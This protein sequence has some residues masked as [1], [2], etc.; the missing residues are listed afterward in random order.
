MTQLITL[1]SML[2]NWPTLPTKNGINWVEHWPLPVEEHL[3]SSWKLETA[4]QP[5]PF[6]DRF[7]SWLITWWARVLGVYKYGILWLFSNQV[8]AALRSMLWSWR[9][10]FRAK[11][12]EDERFTSRCE[13]SRS[14][15]RSWRSILWTSC[16]FWLCQNSY[17]K[18]QVI[19]DL[20][21]KNGGFP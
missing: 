9:L 16:A 8:D 21:S 17:G 18:W 14:S 3:R 2:S 4:L 20:P 12:G 15:L 5:L 10:L 6:F 11:S 13:Y 7:L 19:V 1:V